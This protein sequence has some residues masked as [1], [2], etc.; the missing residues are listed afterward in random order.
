MADIQASAEN[1]LHDGPSAPAVGVTESN[2]SQSGLF[3]IRRR[4]RRQL[5]QSQI[6]KLQQ[7][8]PRGQ[9][10]VI[11]RRR[12]GRSRPHI[13]ADLVKRRHL[14]LV[15][16]GP[17]CLGLHLG[18]ED[19]CLQ[20]G[21]IRRPCQG[22][23]QREGTDIRPDAKDC[24]T[25]PSSPSAC[26]S[27]SPRRDRR[28]QGRGSAPESRLRF[29]ACDPQE[30]PARRARHPSADGGTATRLLGGCGPMQTVLIRLLYPDPPPRS[31]LLAEQPQSGVMM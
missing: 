17:K 18:R 11:Q 16:L 9:R 31:S 4:G 5:D 19:S 22:L 2:R 21:A 14:R 8:L 13:V 28:T 26:R 10:D 27:G 29:V 25:V 1:F 23:R 12:L 6:H 3:P 15:D 24:A 20:P 7:S 30:R